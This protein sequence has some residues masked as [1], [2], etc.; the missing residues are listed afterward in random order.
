MKVALWICRGKKSTHI[1]SH[2]TDFNEFPIV[3]LINFTFYFCL[4]LGRIEFL[5][6]IHYSDFYIDFFVS[7]IKPMDYYEPF[8]L[9]Y[10]FVPRVRAITQYC[11][12]SPSRDI[13]LKSCFHHHMHGSEI[14]F[15]R[16]LMLAELAW[17]G[18][19]RR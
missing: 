14:L 13:S 9:C 15:L 17:C 19:T 18:V 16:L 2:R 10:H 8:E 5:K 12:H 6:H 11:F 3:C 7:D 1:T 4:S